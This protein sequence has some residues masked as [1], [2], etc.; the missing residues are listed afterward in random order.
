[1]THVSHDGDAGNSAGGD[2]PGTTNADRSI[3]SELVSP[4]NEEHGGEHLVVTHTEAHLV[5]ISEQVIVAVDKKKKTTNKEDEKE[6][7]RREKEEKEKKKLEEKEAKKAKKDLEKK[8]KQERTAAAA[9]T[10]AAAKKRTSSSSS[11]SDAASTSDGQGGRK[12]KEKNDKDKSKKACKSVTL[13]DSPVITELYYAEAGEPNALVPHTS[14]THEQHNNH[15]NHDHEPVVIISEQVFESDGPVETVTETDEFGNV[16][17]VTKQRHTTTTVSNER[18]VTVR[19]A[20]SAC[21]QLIWDTIQTV[22]GHHH[23][24]NDQCTPKTSPVGGGERIAHTVTYETPRACEPPQNAEFL[25]C[26]TVT[27]GN[28]TVETVT[29][30]MKKIGDLNKLLLF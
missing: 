24:H 21:A 10:A 13:V 28:R 27:T 2:S 15:H 26:R 22:S 1:L 17:T 3:A 6:R 11:L 19:R 18:V 23:D 16:Y 8:E 30:G 14:T 9:A 5:E 29:V 25:G 20:R 12:K 4:T 7:K